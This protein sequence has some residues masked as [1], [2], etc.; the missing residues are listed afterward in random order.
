MYR[1]TGKWADLQED[2]LKRDHCCFCFNLKDGIVLLS[3]YLMLRAI[4]LVLVSFIPPLEGDSNK[5]GSV[6]V[7]EEAVFLGLYAVN[8]L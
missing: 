6:K 4:L 1:D 2:R 3:T 7:T 8:I 5:K